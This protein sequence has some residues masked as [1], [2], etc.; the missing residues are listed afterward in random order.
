MDL[1]S[2]LGIEEDDQEYNLAEREREIELAIRPKFRLNY[3]VDEKILSKKIPYEVNGKKIPV[4]VKKIQDKIKQRMEKLESQL[5][6][7]YG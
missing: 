6:E 5:N 4:S 7:V 2:L 3:I 1:N